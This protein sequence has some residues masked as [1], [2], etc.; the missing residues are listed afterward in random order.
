MKL[1]LAKASYSHPASKR[2]LY[3]R[4]ALAAIFVILILAQLFAFEKMGTTIAGLVPGLAVA[5]AKPFAA[6]IVVLEVAALPSLLVVPLSPL[7][8]VCSRVA[9]PLA[10]VV[11]YVV[12]Y[13][14]MLTARVPNSG[15]FG[16]DVTIPA[17]FLSLLFVM[18]IFA[19]V[20]S[21]QYADAKEQSAKK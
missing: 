20:V 9:G 16:S 17:N 11:W 6:I 19:A 4:Y 18:I 1:H 7:A 14:G 8:R 10:M 2:I 21:V 5:L 12:I 3:A 15:L 13:C